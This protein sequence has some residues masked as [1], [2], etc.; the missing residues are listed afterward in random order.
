[1]AALASSSYVT[2]FCIIPPSRTWD[3]EV[4][5]VEGG[6]QASVV[7]PAEQGQYFRQSPNLCCLGH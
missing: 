2:A 1:M 3:S 5:K 7:L 4:F 6:S